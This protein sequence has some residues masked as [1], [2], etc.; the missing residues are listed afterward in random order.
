MVVSVTCAIKYAPSKLFGYS[1]TV[2]IPGDPDAEILVVLPSSLDLDKSSVPI[3]LNVSLERPTV[4]VLTDPVVAIPTAVGI[5]STFK[6]EPS[7][8]AWYV[9]RPVLEYSEIPVV[10]LPYSDNATLLELWVILSST[11]SNSWFLEISGL[12]FTRTFA[13]V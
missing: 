10:S 12:I 4:I 13:L 11:D 9:P 8:Y 1:A 6:D 5:K 7:I 2:V 3:P